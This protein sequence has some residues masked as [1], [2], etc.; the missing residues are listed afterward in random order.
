MVDTRRL[1]DRI[2]YKGYKMSY[3][4]NELGMSSASLLNKLDNKTSFKLDEVTKLCKLL[5]ICSLKEKDS[6]FFAQ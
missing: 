5:D 4:A 6:I 3:V 2:S 1:R